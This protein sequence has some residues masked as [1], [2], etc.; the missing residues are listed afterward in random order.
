MKAGVGKTLVWVDMNQKSM[1]QLKYGCLDLQVKSDFGHDGNVKNP[2][3]CEEKDGKMLLVHHNTF[4]M[5]QGADPVTRLGGYYVGDTG[6]RGEDGRW[7]FSIPKSS[8][9]IGV[10][11]DGSAVAM[12]GWRMV[13]RVKMRRGQ[14]LDVE[15]VLLENVVYAD[16]RYWLTLGNSA[17]RSWYIWNGEQKEVW[18][19][20]E[21]NILAEVDV[22]EVEKGLAE[23]GVFGLMTYFVWLKIRRRIMMIIMVAIQESP[24]N[25]HGL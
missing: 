13:E 14:V 16:G 22:L 19:C 2:V 1:Y 17:Y 20:R 9:H 12:E 25:P 6:I 8:V 10:L 24:M 11:E 4:D 5:K 18:R 21:E 3:L 15:P 7:L 23:F